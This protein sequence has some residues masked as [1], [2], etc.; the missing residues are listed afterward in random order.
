MTTPFWNNKIRLEKLC[1]YDELRG[2]CPICKKGPWKII[3]GSPY[4][5]TDVEVYECQWC[6]HEFMVDT[7]ATEGKVYWMI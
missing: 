3:V 7:A 1:R 5:M 2:I 4:S 6:G